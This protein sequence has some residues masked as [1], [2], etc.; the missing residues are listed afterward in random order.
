MFN[1][2]FFLC[3]YP[4]PPLE[5]IDSVSQLYWSAKLTR[6]LLAQCQKVF[7]LE[8]NSREPTS[9]ETLDRNYSQISHMGG[10]K[11]NFRRGN[12]NP[13][14]D[15]CWAI[16]TR[17]HCPIWG[18]PDQK[19]SHLLNLTYRRESQHNLAADLSRA[20]IWAGTVTRGNISCSYMY[21]T[22]GPSYQIY[23]WNRYSTYIEINGFYTYSDIHRRSSWEL[24]KLWNM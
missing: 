14:R 17:F 12:R 7:S 23:F 13:D 11:A 21:L 16:C 1:F 8:G 24:V 22:E 19:F 15:I 10:K 20:F 3:L 18:Q 4:H 6:V 9:Y 5:S 2:S